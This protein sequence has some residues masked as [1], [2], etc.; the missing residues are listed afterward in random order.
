MACFSFSCSANSD[1]VEWPSSKSEKLVLPQLRW[2]KADKNSYYCYYGQYLEPLVTVI[3]KLLV[4]YLAG[5]VPDNVS[6]IASS[7]FT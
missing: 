1:V 5:E 4:L 7:L 2:D 3:H 6:V